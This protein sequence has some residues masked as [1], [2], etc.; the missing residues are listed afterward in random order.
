M[1]H[2]SQKFGKLQQ[3]FLCCY[4]LNKIDWASLEL[5]VDLE[6]QE[7]LMLATF[8]HPLN[9]RWP[10]RRKYKEAFI[11]RLLELLKDEEEVHDGI[12]NSLCGQLVCEAAVPQLYDYKHYVLSHPYET[13][14]TLRES[15]SFVSEGTT[16]LCTWEAALALSDYL[17]QNKNVAEHKNIIELGAGAG[18]CG[19]VL[20]KCLLHVQEVLLTDGSEPC[21][22]LMRENIAL[23][24]HNAVDQQ[25]PQVALLRWDEVESFP[26]A[27]YAAPDLL[28]AADVIYDDSQFEA[29]LSAMDYIFEMRDNRIEMLLASTVRN[30]AT[31]AKF[32]DKLDTRNYK[33]TPCASTQQEDSLFCRDYTTEVKIVCITR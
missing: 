5:P 31:M 13:T 6:T 20:K 32:L 16:G 18:L 15:S 8:A 24:F 12:Y 29:L 14:I 21:V 11:K 22:Q 3:Q 9:R 27:K 26:W 33:I 10:V 19:I 4:P 2:K 28:L 25:P 30:T 7:E 17:L 23:N 1:S